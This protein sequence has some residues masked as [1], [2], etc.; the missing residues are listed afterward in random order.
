[1]IIIDLND[2][3]VNNGTLTREVIEQCL[4]ECLSE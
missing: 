2:L 3:T 1:M 4:L